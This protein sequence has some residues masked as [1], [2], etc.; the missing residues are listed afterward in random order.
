MTTPTPQFASPVDVHAAL[1]RAHAD[2]AEYINQALAELPIL[3]KFLAS[4]FRRHRA[5][6]KG[7]WA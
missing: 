4:A 3:F 2:R 6:H 1:A 5:P 7:A